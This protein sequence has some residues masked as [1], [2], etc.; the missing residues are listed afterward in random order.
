[1]NNLVV[2][3]NP[4]TKAIHR[5]IDEVLELKRKVMRTK[6]DHM[7]EMRNMLT[8]DQRISFDM[9]LLERTGHSKGHRHR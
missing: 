5:K 8:Q 6:Y 1:M 9:G 3:D 2:K 7:I 4:D